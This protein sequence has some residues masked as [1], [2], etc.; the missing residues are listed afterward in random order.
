[1]DGLK[2]L[3]GAPAKIRY[4]KGCGRESTSYITV[5]IGNLFHLDDGQKKGGLSAA[6]FNNITMQGTA[7]LLRIDPFIDFRWTLFSPDPEKINYDWFSA[8]WEGILSAPATGKI[9]IGLEGNDGYRLYLDEQLVIDNWQK[10]TFGRITTPYQFEAGRE[11][12]IKLEF[13]ESAGDARLKLIWDAG[14]HEKWKEEIADAVKIAGESDIALVVAGIEEGEFQ[15]RA[16]LNLP[17]HQEEMIRKIA[18]T[19]TPLVVVLIGGSAVTM[20]DWIDEPA[21]ILLAWYPGEAG[22]EALAEVLFGDYNP[23]GRLPVT[24][25]MHESQLPLYYNHKPTGRGDDYVN[26]TGKPL[27]PFGFGLSYSSFEYTDLKIEKAQNAAGQNP[28]VSFR[29]RN[30]GKFAGDEVVQLYIRDILASVARPLRE[31]KGFQRVHLKPGESKDLT[32]E[33]TPDLLSMLDKDL[34]RIIEPGE[35]RIMIGASSTDIRLRGFISRD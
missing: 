12:A 5:P 21:A 29:I 18:E 20:T 8:R 9:N 23:A 10:Q 35:F 16:Y 22:G 15:D 6:Y 24:F 34:N 27:F 28:L 3:P 17:G 1:L 4:A 14:V 33:I 19:G 31:L 32:F 13:F 30:S 11:Y 26:L 7:D 2:T 25:P